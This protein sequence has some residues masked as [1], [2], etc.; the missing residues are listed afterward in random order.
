MT[1]S[2]GPGPCFR[3]THFL[4][5]SIRRGRTID[6]AVRIGHDQLRRPAAVTN[7][8][9]EFTRE[10]RFREAEVAFQGAEKLRQSRRIAPKG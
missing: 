9:T 2:I 5:P 6:P 1:T 10:R 7:A 8:E 3:G 4:A